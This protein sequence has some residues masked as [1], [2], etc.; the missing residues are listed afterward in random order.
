VIARLF[1][2]TFPGASGAQLRA[3]AIDAP[4]IAAEIGVAAAAAPY[5]FDTQQDMDPALAAYWGV[6]LAPLG[7]GK[8]RER[9]P[10]YLVPFYQT[11]SMQAYIAAVEGDSGFAQATRADRTGV[12]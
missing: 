11:R 7:T 10:D 1:E 5:M 9:V 8:E 4:S 3:L 6:A 12:F 2:E